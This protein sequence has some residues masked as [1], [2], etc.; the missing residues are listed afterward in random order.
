MSQISHQNPRT[1]TSVRKDR[2][3]GHGGGLLISIHRAITLSKQP[4]S[5]ESQSDPHLEELTIKADNYRE[6][7]HLLQ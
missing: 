6:S 4:L 2:P 1:P 7:S 5:P 3:H